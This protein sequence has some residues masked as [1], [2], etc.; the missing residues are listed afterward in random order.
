[1]TTY[2]PKE[3][4]EARG[5]SYRG[6]THDIELNYLSALLQTEPLRKICEVGSGYGRIYSALEKKGLLFRA[7]LTMYDFVESMRTCCLA[8]TGQRPNGWDGHQ[9]PEAEGAFDLVISSYALLHVPPQDLAGIFAEHVRISNGLIF[10]TSSVG[11]EGRVPSKHCFYHDYNSF[12]SDHSLRVELHAKYGPEDQI[13][14]WI[15]SK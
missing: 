15:L 11:I 4:W 10:L 14:T 5:K 7:R 6:E 9:I 3:Y 13:A 12:F 8:A 1:M 2:N